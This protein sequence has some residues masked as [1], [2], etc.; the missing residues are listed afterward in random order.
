MLELTDDVRQGLAKTAGHGALSFNT[1]EYAKA[2]DLKNSADDSFNVRGLPGGTFGQSVIDST[3]GVAGNIDDFLGGPTGLGDYANNY[4]TAQ[5][6]AMGE[7]P[8][9]D[10]S[11]D[12]LINGLPRDTGNLIGSGISLA[13]PIAAATFAAPFVGIGATAAGIGGALAGAGLESMAEG[14]QKMRDSLANGDS[15]ET[16]QDKAR[17]VAGENMALLAPTNILGL[18][19]LKKVGQGLKT[20]YNGG[21][22]VSAAGG[23]LANYPKLSQAAD[24]A[25]GAGW[26]GLG[27]MNEGAQE[28]WQQGIQDSVEPNTDW[29]VLPWNWNDEQAEAF[30]STI[31]P[32]ALMAGVGGGARLAAR[33]LGASD[34]PQGDLGIQANNNLFG[35]GTA[36]IST[37]GADIDEQVAHLK[38]GYQSVIPQVAGVLVNDFGI[39][40]AQ[41]SS[42]F[43]TREHNKEVGG[44]ENSYHV[45]DGEH[46]DALD[47]V[48]PDG[49]S[50]ETAEAI[51]QR[52]KN[53]GVFDE[54]LFHDAGSGYHLHLGGLKTDNIGNSYGS[55]SGNA[56]VD[57]A[58]NEMAEKYN[59]DP[60]LL[61]AMAEQES[62]FNQSAQ[63]EAGAMGIMQLMP[64][65]A[66]GMGVDPS[67]LR[68][69][70]EGGAKHLRQMLDKYDG[71]VE[72][73]LAA[74]NAGPGSLDSVNGDIS[75][76]SGETQK[77][78]PSV[79]E[80]YNKFKNKSGGGISSSG[81][82]LDWD[83]TNEDFSK[84][85]FF[86]KDGEQSQGTANEFLENLAKLEESDDQATKEKGRQAQ[87]ILQQYGDDTEKLTEKAKELGYQQ[88][89]DPAE[90]HGRI[91]MRRIV[92]TALD[93]G[94]VTFATKKAADIFASSP[95]GQTMER[96]GKT[97]KVTD[98]FKM[99]EQVNAISQ[100]V[101]S[102]NTA[103]NK[104]VK[105]GVMADAA[106]ANRELNGQSRPPV[107]QNDSVLTDEDRGR[108]SS[109]MPNLPSQVQQQ[110]QEALA[111]NDIK[112]VRLLLDEATNS[113]PLNA[114][115]DVE[116]AK[117]ITRALLQ[118]P[119][120]T[121]SWDGNGAVRTTAI[122]GFINSNNLDGLN[123]ANK[124]MAQNL[125]GKGIDPLEVL[126]Q[127]I[128]KP[129][130]LPAVQGNRMPSTDVQREEPAVEG[131]V[132][133]TVITPPYNGKPAYNE[134]QLEAPAVE[135]D[136]LN[137]EEFL[138][139]LSPVERGFMKYLDKM[140]DNL[141]LG[142]NDVLEYL[143]ARQKD[144]FNKRMESVIQQGPQGLTGAFYTSDGKM[145]VDNNM[146][147]EV[148]NA[149]NQLLSMRKNFG[150]SLANSTAD[151]QNEY[152][153]VESVVKDYLTTTVTEQCKN[154]V[155]WRKL[156]Y[157][158][159]GLEA[160][161]D[162]ARRYERSVSEEGKRGSTK[163]YRDI[164]AEE[165]QAIE[166]SA[167]AWSGAIHQYGTTETRLHSFLNTL[168]SNF[169]K[170]N[171]G[172]ALRAKTKYKG[173]PMNKA[174]R[175]E[176]LIRD[177]GRIEERGKEYFAVDANGGEVKVTKG[178]HNYYKW[179]RQN[180]FAQQERAP[181]GAPQL[182]ENNGVTEDNYR[183]R[184]PEYGNE[185]ES[186]ESTGTNSENQSSSPTSKNAE[187]ELADGYSTESGK[188]L[189][190]ANEREFIVK[191]DGSKDFGEIS[192]DIS[193][194][195]KEQSGIEL[196]PGKIRLRVGNEKQG[197]IHAKKH[198]QQAKTDGY[199]SIEDMIADVASNFNEIYLRTPRKAGDKPTYSLVKLGD[200][201]T[202]KKNGTAPVYFDLQS[203]GNGQYYIVI[204]AIPKGD[205][206]LKRQTKKDHLIYSSPGLDAATTSNGSAVS[207][208]ISNNVGAEQNVLPTSD[209]S[210]GFSNSTIPQNQDKG[211]ENPNASN[212]PMRKELIEQAAANE[213]TWVNS[214]KS[215]LHLEDDN[216]TVVKLTPKELKYYQDLARKGVVA[217]PELYEESQEDVGE[218]D[219][220]VEMSKEQKQLYDESSDDRDMPSVEDEAEP[221]DGEPR[222]KYSR[223][224][225]PVDE[226]KP[227]RHN[228]ECR[229][230]KEQ[231]K[232]YVQS[233]LDNGALK[234]L[235]PSD[236]VN[237]AIEKII[238]PIKREVDNQA[239]RYLEAG[240]EPEYYQARLNMV[241]YY[242]QLVDEI[243]RDF[244]AGDR[245]SDVYGRVINDT[246]FRQSAGEGSNLR[247]SVQKRNAE[248]E[249][250]EDENS[251]VNSSSAKTG[252]TYEN[253]NPK[254]QKVLDMMYKHSSRD[255]SAFSIEP[256]NP[257]SAESLKENGNS[258]TELDRLP[259]VP[260]AKL[261]Q[262]E[263]K[264]V[265]FGKAIG[266]PV[267]FVES[268]ETTNRGVFTHNG[269]IFINRKAKVPAH[270]IFVHEFVHW[271]KASPENAGAYDVLHAC[272]ENSSGLFNEAR[273]NKYR[274]KIFDGEKMTDEEI[275]EE[276][277]C[278]AMT[279]TES[280]EKLMRAVNNVDGDLATRVAG[281]LKAMWDKF[282]KAIGFNPKILSRKQQ[283]PNALSVEELQKA[284]IAFNKIL[285]NIKGNDGKPVFY[286]KGTDLVLRDT[287]V[288]PVDTYQI[289]P[290][291]YTYAVAY[292]KENKDKEP[293]DGNDNQQDNMVIE[294]DGD[295]RGAQLV[296]NK[297]LTQGLKDLTRQTIKDEI[298]ENIKDFEKLN[299]PVELDKA[300]N[301]LPFFKKIRGQFQ[302]NVITSN[303]EY[304]HRMATRYEY[305]RRCFLNDS[306][307]PNESVRRVDVH[308][309][310]DQISR[311]DGNSFPQGDNAG[312]KQTLSGRTGK[313]LLNSG[314]TSTTPGEYKFIKNHF[315]K[316]VDDTLKHSE[317]GAFSIGN[318]YSRGVD[319]SPST[320]GVAIAA[321]ANNNL[322]ANMKGLAKKANA[323]F[324]PFHHEEL[325]NLRI[326]KRDKEKD[327][328]LIEYQFV[329]PTR[330]SKKYKVIHPFVMKGKQAM[331]K[332]EKLRFE[333]NEGMNELD[334]LLGWREGFHRNDPKFKERKEAL[335][336]ILLKGDLERKE[337]TNEELIK[338]GYDAETIKGYHK[339][340]ALLYK[341]WKLADETKSRIKY[342]S[343]TSSTQR[344]AEADFADLK[345]KNP[346]AEI[347]SKVH[348]PDGTVTINYK[349]P[350]VRRV[351]KQT[352]LPPELENLRKNKDVHIVETTQSL[353]GT[354][355][356]TYYQR[357]AGMGKLKGYIPHIFHGWYVCKV[358]KDGKAI[359][360]EDGNVAMDNIMTTANSLSEAA[361]LGRKFAKA[362]P[363]A[364]YRI[365]PQTFSAPG[366]QEQAIVMGDFDY[367]KIVGQVADSMS[368][369]ISDAQA[370][371][372]NTVKMENRGRFYG[373]AK[374]RKGFKGFEQNVY[375]ATMKYFN[376][377]A[378]Y[379][380]MDSF[381]RDS[382]SMY[383]RIFGAFDDENVT[384]RSAMAKWTK[385]YISDM[386]GTPTWIEKMINNTLHN[387]G[388]GEERAGGRPALW[389]QQKIFTYPMTILKLGVFNPSSALLNLTQLFNLYGAMGEKVLS[390]QAYQRLLH[391][392]FADTFRAMSNK[393]SELGKLL[394]KELGLDYQIGM[395]IASGYSNAEVSNLASLRGFA[396][397][398][399]GK[400]MYLFRQSDAFAR[401]VT[402]LTAYNKALDE[403]KSKAEAIEYAKEINDKV[404]FDYSVADEPTIF[405]ALGPISKVFLQFKKYPVKQL[406]LFQDFYLDGRE[407]GLNRK[408]SFLRMVKYVAPYMAMSGMMGIPFVSFLG[409]LISY[410]ASMIYGDDDWDWEK[411]IKQLMITEFGEDSPITQWWLYGAGSF[412]GLNLGG[413]VGVGDF[414]G[415]DSYNS[416]DG[417]GGLMW[418]QT[419]LGSTVNQV[420]KQLSYRNYAEALKAIN[421]TMGN[422]ALA[423]KGEVRTTRG[424]M[425]YQYQNMA[426]RMWR[427]IGFTPLNETLAG[428]L[429]SNEYAEKQEQT[430]AKQEAV[431]DFLADP[432]SE[433]AARLNELGVTPKSLETEAARRTMNRHQLNE[434][435]KEKEEAKKKKKPKTYSASDYLKAV[436]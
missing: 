105:N 277:I 192:S 205:K 3:L 234:T 59:L 322:L 317:Q 270:S 180:G 108:L 90:V 182:A 376:Q 200:K 215:E 119:E 259:K 134:N 406:E 44:A 263:Q 414:L 89:V 354:T 336:E 318:K 10:F 409:G 104:T 280:A 212:E 109:V 257:H 248:I 165:G 341:A 328:N 359:V 139:G 344:R 53:S 298:T 188:P 173:Q 65:T 198:E 420:R 255:K 17:T 271:L 34:V 422:I 304:M 386:N 289:N 91:P 276:I 266:V 174:G 381:K 351:D 137:S 357:E 327:L 365:I 99:N 183:A 315:D 375:L 332:Q 6:M 393:D 400:S 250:R 218:M 144:I 219:D 58:I 101:Y 71:D 114:E 142:F 339:M 306:R 85:D 267:H 55:Y 207:R 254:T 117:A 314:I 410:G 62:G 345:D 4:V 404:N 245:Q 57:S 237:T 398:L 382:I 232:R 69:N 46:G 378:R 201:N 342:Q 261:R 334:K 247:K 40:G 135:S 282:C 168:G 61:A 303:P 368:M 12:Y 124:Y 258:N 16:A 407:L 367:A 141:Q 238:A 346:F 396:G 222:T 434:L 297:Y 402:L 125:R 217:K 5:E 279:H 170:N 84:L 166:D 363:N 216:D 22:A 383:N 240:H 231:A 176:T 30:K 8:K 428:D 405:R 197:L 191:P 413:R 384:K 391:K 18:G 429:A 106:A 401:G 122:E 37:Q 163:S 292:S 24:F 415:S 362:N 358:D 136:H 25:K 269:E 320:D 204:T 41:I 158:I 421:P 45:G 194:A 148:Q 369:S 56:D 427:A 329:S 98:N 287:D 118:N 423:Y 77:Y 392:G 32:T 416:A 121:T 149:W 221:T 20:A 175:V 389:L 268:N 309:K 113:T 425:K 196:S 86:P 129:N 160:I 430:K 145:V 333:F 202:G 2:M 242:K 290:I 374:Q 366:A 147:Q 47:I 387:F 211:N 338:A 272:L 265:R 319:L 97:F 412:I 140:F 115:T 116:K 305:A 264:I 167:V 335:N 371:L 178:E 68:G 94:Q 300:L 177:G 220:N 63:S 159:T 21:K 274:G 436:Q 151:I 9:A 244:N 128:E 273:I 157:A 110:I 190:E 360:D 39:E 380:A 281:Y 162:K 229:D 408:Q 293:I 388:L 42:G 127:N 36:E 70:L 103:R 80:R 223:E 164:S 417:L 214:K 93:K 199:S 146:P 230:V 66:E 209:K 195:V 181:E 38:D 156:N 275:V 347:I 154:N 64:G 13:A 227:T 87:D 82:I 331:A 364:N 28:A 337:F 153:R 310:Q 112:A 225:S 67:D 394:W 226:K 353:K 111:E 377:T 169:T 81:N 284:D 43:R 179:L 50:A 249:T 241:N 251:G 100:Q 260:I 74:Y 299:D 296:F 213:D 155:S 418:N 11:W 356:V 130:T 419:T 78:V 52:F 253:Y 379:A 54:V 73:A 355:Q 311:T 424:R 96:Q 321:R 51:K 208:S 26:A 35:A 131:T 399:A 27:A 432:S 385:Q 95:I 224:K 48:L 343:I 185:N 143:R 49:T 373:Y 431:D 184:Q 72:K 206:S 171:H 307:I 349:S 390:P 210:S 7:K 286:R 283:L 302:N 256:I 79:M 23:A 60:A 186:K 262:S 83:S 397:R 120:A 348:N 403:G 138:A 312:K 294:F 239:A 243:R 323:K 301:E 252:K 285:M 433:N 123:R 325:E 19:A 203:D 33:K 235:K 161:A 313:R 1:E 411:K 152:M 14:G 233:R 308:A 246:W 88:T 372:D 126:N 31:G 340:R 132:E 236:D 395:D 291:G 92:S 316:L 187:I 228:V 75:K 295:K 350:H 326:D 426:E 189:N 361:K 102:S 278:D 193:K 370:M 324:N 352:V 107:Q 150:A 172:M 435:A 330:E 288:K 15:L 133:D 29:G 76:L